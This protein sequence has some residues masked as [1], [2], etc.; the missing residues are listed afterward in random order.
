MTDRVSHDHPTIETVSATV[1]RYG[2]TSRPE[3]RVAES[4]SVEQGSVVRLVLGGTE[5]YTE[6]QS[7]EGQTPVFRG[8]YPSPRTARKP[9]GTTNHLVG[10]VE[11]RNPEWGRTVQLDVV[12]PGF[13][14]G[15]RA[16]GESA[17]YKTGRPD[18]GL[19]DIAR[20]LDL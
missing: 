12:E 17:T 16:P 13:K 9:A 5:Y 6:V 7:S 19:A 11:E 4:L 3:I 14:Y 18:E 1:A 20:D 10:W 8:A 15:L 2:G